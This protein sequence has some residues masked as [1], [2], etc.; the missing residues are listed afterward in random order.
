MNIHEV[1]L[2]LDQYRKTPNFNSL[3][4][5]A[6]QFQS[7]C[8]LTLKLNDRTLAD[9]ST[10]QVQQAVAQSGSNL[11][12][13]YELLNKVAAWYKGQSQVSS[14]ALQ[15]EELFLAEKNHINL[16]RDLDLIMGTARLVSLAQTFRGIYGTN[17]TWQGQGLAERGATAA[18]RIALLVSLRPL[19]RERAVSLG[20]LNDLVEAVNESG[21]TLRLEELAPPAPPPPP[22]TPAPVVTA[23][24][25]PPANT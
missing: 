9:L 13:I 14:C 4:L 6:G 20:K 17:I 16:G 10:G 25:P 23:V 5:L 15:I 3:R 1:R 12:A 19:L 24:T 18:D 21:A 11:K 8:G 22:E 2:N 7:N